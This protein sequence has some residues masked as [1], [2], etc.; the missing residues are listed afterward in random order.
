ME[1][2]F[3]GLMMETGNLVEAPTTPAFYS[4]YNVVCHGLP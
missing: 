1:M 2:P 3:R 4:L